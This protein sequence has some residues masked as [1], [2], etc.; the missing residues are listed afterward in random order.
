M[1]LQRHIS[2]EWQTYRDS[3][4]LNAVYTV[5]FWKEPPGVAE[6]KIGAADAILRTT[7]ELHQHFLL[8]W[9]DKLSQGGPK[10][11]HDYVN[12]MAAVRDYARDA[13]N[14]V[15]RDASEINSEVANETRDAIVALARIRLA[16]TVGVAVIGA[17][18]GIAFAAAAAGGAATGVTV[19][20][21]EAGASSLAFGATG[22][23][24]S[25]TNSII[26]TWEK[27][28][29]AQV[30]AVS[31]DTGKAAV[32]E[33]GGH[34]A[35]HVI[36]HALKEQAHSQQII[37]SAEGQIRKYSERLAQAGLRKAAARKATSIVQG[38]TRQI[39]RQTE[40]IAGMANK[41]KWAGRAAKGIP[42]VFAAWDI[43]D[44]IGDYN[45]T[46]KDLH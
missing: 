16:A 8:V 7:D 27:G 10:A 26:K 15:F 36:E 14:S 30:A 46:V 3:R 32:S 5:L 11:A 9:I 42:V 37:K 38:A 40:T 24:F 35:G 34:V 6:V 44:A 29:S 13:V 41:M 23:G 43:I 33:A 12:Q 4:V 25:A 2:L 21:V 1:A 19:F 20:G 39:A 45:E 22:F 28:P 17:A 18:A 31:L